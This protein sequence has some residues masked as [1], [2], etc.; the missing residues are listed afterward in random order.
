M[1]LSH[2]LLDSLTERRFGCRK[3]HGPSE[4]EAAHARVLQAEHHCEEAVVVVALVQ[5]PL[6]SVSGIGHDAEQKQ[7]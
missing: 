3:A 5:Q 1:P 2:A 6:W 4:L 7:I